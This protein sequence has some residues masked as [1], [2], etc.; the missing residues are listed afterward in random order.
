MT[1]NTLSGGMRAFG[2]ALIAVV[3][4]LPQ[5]AHARKIVTEFNYQFDAGG[6]LHEFI[7]NDPGAGADV[8]WQ[9]GGAL[10]SP[11]TV[12]RSRAAPPSAYPTM[13]ELSSEPATAGMPASMLATTAER[14]AA[15]V[16]ASSALHQ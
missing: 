9:A 2:F 15:T 11:H 10:G 4:A 14:A 16:L 13:S 5:A 6:Q 7:H 8:Q 3:M 12:R 1:K